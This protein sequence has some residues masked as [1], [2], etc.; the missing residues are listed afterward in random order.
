MTA[1]RVDNKWS[2]A[3]TG[4]QEGC[5]PFPLRPLILTDKTVKDS[6]SAADARVQDAKISN[7]LYTD[8][9]LLIS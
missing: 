6:E 7:L 4:I 5:K 9:M 3:N 8:D 2:D 1:I